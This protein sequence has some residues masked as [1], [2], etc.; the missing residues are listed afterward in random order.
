MIFK[1]KFAQVSFLHVYH[2]STI[3]PYWWLIVRTTPGGDAWLTAFL[4][5]GVHVVMYS[6]YL[7]A[8]LR[9]T[10]VLLLFFFSSFFSGL[11]ALL[12]HDLGVH[13]ACSSFLP[14]FSVKH[15]VAHQPLL[16]FGIFLDSFFF[17]TSSVTWKAW[18]TRGQMVQFGLFLVQSVY[19]TAT[20]CHTGAIAV[21]GKGLIAYAVSLLALFANFYVQAYMAKGSAAGSKGKGKGKAKRA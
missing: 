18:V 4:N 7:L 10:S 19:V 5:S 1:H 2:H 13:C 14:F 15:S 16:N 3:L 20:A 11:Q 8:A 21:I 6:Y 12:R 17:P 9:V